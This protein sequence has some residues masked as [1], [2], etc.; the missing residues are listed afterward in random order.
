MFNGCEKLQYL[1]IS[2]FDVSSVIDME[3]MFMDCISLTSLDLPN[4]VAPNVVTLERM[5]YNCS[6]LN[7]INLSN[8]I[9]PSVTN[10]TSMFEGCFNLN[11]INLNSFVE[12]ND[13]DA[14]NILADTRDDL[15]YCVSDILGIPKIYEYLRIKLCAYKDC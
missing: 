8:F 13:V 6:S 5:F 11:Y 3:Q 10:M 9:I 2:N 15:I 14:S 7:F 4:F 12:N 1:K